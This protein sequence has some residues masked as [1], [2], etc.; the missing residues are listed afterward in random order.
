VLGLL[1]PLGAS[2]AADVAGPPPASR[3]VRIGE[4]GSRTGLRVTLFAYKVRVSGRGKL[5]CLHATLPHDRTLS[6]GCFPPLSATGGI[7][8]TGVYAASWIRCEARTA[9]FFGVA[10]RRVAQVDLLLPRGHRAIARLFPIPR[11]FPV[12]GSFFAAA[13][14]E[15]KAAL[16]GRGRFRNERYVSAIVGLD[17]RGRPV[18]ARSADPPF[19]PAGECYNTDAGF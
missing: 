8:A 10:G 15:P 4:V 17:R 14:V 16:A 19:R 12:R 11:S 5:V 7:Q 1:L 9:V 6:S 3:P 2:A 18:S 13:V